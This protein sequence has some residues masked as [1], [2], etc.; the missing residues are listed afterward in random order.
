MESFA[1]LLTI[2][3]IVIPSCDLALLHRRSGYKGVNP[4][5][6]MSPALTFSSSFPRGIH[7]VNIRRKMETVRMQHNPVIPAKAGIQND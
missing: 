1:Q 2:N 7:R 6:L 3:N 4:E 5:R